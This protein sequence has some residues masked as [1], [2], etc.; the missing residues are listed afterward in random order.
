MVVCPDAGSL[1]LTLPGDE[2]SEGD[3]RCL[4]HSQLWVSNLPKFAMQWL[5]VDSNLRPSSCKAQN[6][7]LHHRAPVGLIYIK[8]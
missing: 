6:I 4:P 2:M 7:P 8:S 1:A 3:S 5:E